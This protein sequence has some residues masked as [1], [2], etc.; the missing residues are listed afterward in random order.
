MARCGG[1]ALHPTYGYPRIWYLKIRSV[2][3]PSLQRIYSKAI[4]IQEHERSRKIS[5]TR[6]ES[7]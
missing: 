3:L 7:E 5:I 4:S 2:G 1:I 6:K